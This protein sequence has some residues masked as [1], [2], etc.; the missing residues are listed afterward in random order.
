[1]II[2]CFELFIETPSDLLARAQTYSSYKHNNTVKYLIGIAPSGQITYISNGWGGR[3]SD[4]HITEYSNFVTNLLPGDVVLADRGFDV[5]D[6]LGFVQAEV[7]IP[8]FMRGKTQLSAYEVESTRR[9][10]HLHIHVE[11]VIGSLCN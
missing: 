6:V 1:M 9:I 4:K 7:Q 5:G 2:D 8:T 10:A 3:A 11:R